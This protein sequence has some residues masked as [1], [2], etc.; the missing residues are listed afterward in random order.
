MCFK[1][2]GPTCFSKGL[3]NFQGNNN[4]PNRGYLSTYHSPCDFSSAFHKHLEKISIP[5]INSLN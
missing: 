5:V 4:F 1:G 3:V 2:F